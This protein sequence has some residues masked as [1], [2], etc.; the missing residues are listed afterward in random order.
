MSGARGTEALQGPGAEVF[1][2]EHQYVTRQIRGLRPDLVECSRAS[3]VVSEHVS[4]WV[5]LYP[6]CG[7]LCGVCIDGE[8]STVENLE[9]SN[10]LEIVGGQASWPSG[11]KTASPFSCFRPATSRSKK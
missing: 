2:V 4:S 5:G 8:C 6:Y 7:S 10:L 1:E 11:L 3:G 9:F